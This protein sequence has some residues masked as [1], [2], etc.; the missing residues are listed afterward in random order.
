MKIFLQEALSIIKNYYIF[1]DTCVFLDIA[2]LDKSVR[3]DFING[4]FRFKE[5]MCAF[6]TVEPVAWEFFLGSTPK[7]LEIKK[8]YFNKLIT[9]IIPTRSLKEE[10]IENLII[11]YGRDAM[12]TL[13]YTDL[14]LGTAIKQY[15]KSLLLTRNY[16]DFPARIFNC[17]AVFTIS[18]YKEVR[19]YGF[20]EYK[21][22][23][24]SK[25]DSIENEVPF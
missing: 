10:T 2:V 18:L 24:I 21:G 16:K 17:L 23:K 13:S 12:G 8:E 11:E 1:I 9:T 5:E 14:C 15:P 20:Y 7:D 25:K 4:L 22:G 3:D 6:V 19:T